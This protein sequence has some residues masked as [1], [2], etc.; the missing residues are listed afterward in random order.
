MKGFLA[1]I[2]IATTLGSSPQVDEP[3]VH[4]HDGCHHVHQVE[5]LEVARASVFKAVCSKGDLN[6][7]YQNRSDAVKAAEAHQKATGHKTSVRK[8]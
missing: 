1:A 6:A 2:M 3:A 5:V 4:Q 7:T 8:Q